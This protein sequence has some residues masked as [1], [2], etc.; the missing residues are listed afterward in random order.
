[1]ADWATIKVEQGIRK[2]GAYLRDLV[3]PLFLGTFLARG[4][5]LNLYPFGV[6]FVA[7]LLLRGGR[8]LIPGL[9][10]VLVGT[11]TLQNLPLLLKFLIILAILSLTAPFLRR[12]K[13][14]SIYMGLLTVLAT[15]LVS[16]LALGYSKSNPAALF[17]AGIN[18]VLTGGFG[19]I[20]WYALANLGA[21]WRGEFNREQGIA[22]LILLIGVISGLQGLH[23]AEINFPVL[24]L[25][26]F[27]L[28]VAERFGAGTASGVGALLG[29]LPQMSFDVQNLT[30]AG[31][32][33]LAGFCTGAFQR[34][35]KLGIGLA[36]SAVNLTLTIFLRQEVV[37]SQL[38]SSA[39]GLLLFFLWPGTRP[40]KEF[41]KPKRIPEVETT[42]S[43]VKALA[44]IF[45][46]IALSYQAAEAEVSEKT[47]PEIPELMNILVERVCQSCPT[48]GTCWEREFYKTYRYLFDLFSLVET[49]GQVQVQDLPIEWK[50]QCGRLKEMLLGIQFIMEQ[51]KSQETWRRRLVSNQEAIARQF[52]SVSQVIGNLAKEL[53]TRNNW[54]DVRAT[55]LTRRRRHFLDV[56]V[57]SF[58]KSGSGINGDNYASLA[59]AS[60]QHA[61]II[62]DG[63]GT[64]ESAAKM[65]AAALTLLEQL[66]NTGF[67]PAGAVQALN[68]ILVLRS[69]E[70]SFVTVDMAVL[71]LESEGLKLIKAG[72]V[73]SYILGPDGVQVFS[74]SG[75]PAGILD[76]IEVPGMEVVLRPS[77]CLIMVSDGIGDAVRDGGDW[78]ADFLEQTALTNAQELADKIVL[79]ARRL[80][81]G[82]MQD[83]GV[84]LVV[85]KNYWN[86]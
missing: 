9:V 20:F 84:V 4:S 28:F 53:N 23:V 26:F 30:T 65:S 57:A 82:E 3:L 42:V 63:M 67:E 44:E 80:S 79:E 41:L 8:G 16:S 40:R 77:E 37:F 60:T 25:S 46:Q 55:S 59:F 62:S 12:K 21:V 14:A 68:S 73:A 27:V 5:L 50:R 70:E 36:F 34:L 18:G 6:A 72:A 74:S 7:A 15:V 56:G 76:Q 51:E 17:S 75:L 29:F 38:V 83:D 49:H 13:H 86:E 10:G 2:E 81:G 64:G 85:R 31:I 48:I 78:L 1:M 11:L 39:L 24:V 45:D 66:L 19:I 22:W 54:H 43:K 47:R 52:Q 61:F 33:G 35:G 58:S 71:D 69:P 32:Y